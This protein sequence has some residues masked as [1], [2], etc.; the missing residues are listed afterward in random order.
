MLGMTANKRYMI[1]CEPCAYKKIVES[2][3][4]LV[5]IRRPKVPGGS[6]Y[7]DPLTKK[8]KTKKATEQPPSVK[9]PK[10]G[11]GVVLKRLPDVFVKAEKEQRKRIE[12]EEE[13]QKEA[14]RKIEEP[15]EL[16]ET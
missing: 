9:C 4:G 13:R 2:T 1:F 11:R 10:C 7:I 12:E 14:Q 3:D 5:E 6:P 8:T 15:E 16:D